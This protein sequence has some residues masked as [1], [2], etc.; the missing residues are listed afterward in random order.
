M[1]G[2]QKKIYQDPE[3]RKT[4]E[5]FLALAQPAPQ[6]YE[7]SC[8][9]VQKKDPNPCCYNTPVSLSLS[10]QL[11]LQ[12]VFFELAKQS[13]INIVFDRPCAKTTT[14]LY[15]A[16]DKPL[17]KV[18]D[19]LSSTYDLRYYYHN[20]TLHITPDTPN[21]KIYN[22]QFL[23]GS[24]KTQTETSVR[25]D[26]LGQSNKNKSSFAQENGA[27]I[28]I[29]SQNEIN[30]WEELEK[31][32]QYILKEPI[33]KEKPAYALNRYAG[34]LSV[35]GNSKQHQA[36][37]RYLKHLQKLATTQILIEAKI[38]EIELTDEHKNGIQWDAL[39]ALS[40]AINAKASLQEGAFFSFFVDTKNLSA[41]V[42]FMNKFGT[43]RTLSN[44]RLTVLNN[45]A[46]VLKVARN[47]V[48][49]EMQMDEVMMTANSPHIQK[50]RSHIQTVPIGLILYVHPVVNFETGQIVLF[51][52]PTI[53]RI[54]DVKNDPAIALSMKGM[55]TTV[56]SEIPV[57]QVREMDSVVAAKENQV[58]ILGGLMEET[59]DYKRS[60]IPLL[61]D[62]P[63]LGLLFSFKERVK[64]L[65]ELV[66]LLRPRI[67][68]SDHPKSITPADQR[69]YQEFTQDP[70]PFS[71]HTS[72]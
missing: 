27:S 6:Q 2:C 41:F 1:S 57:I 56:K 35:W 37:G 20:D 17:E 53:S 11:P 71:V 49:F 43:V 64:R 25:T 42:N 58:I 8:L 63:L 70:R 19:D 40:A 54:I 21:L 7:E 50:A 3:I 32:I 28:Q 22:V 15:H 61:C 34:T 47:E 18:L 67:L 36:I 45:Q 59:S 10:G 51:L 55:A 4:K 29:K 44:P 65:T 12:E 48:F 46:A 13:N 66:I 33:N 26:I 9:N 24:R 31:N 14:V 23:I 39:P 72:Q 30:F 16:K 68:R 52:H 69:I 38:I 60:G 62:I 5:D